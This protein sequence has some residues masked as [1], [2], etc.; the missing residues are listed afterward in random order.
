MAAISQE[1]FLL[2]QR[3]VLNSII[4]DNNPLKI[5]A[6]TIHKDIT[7]RI[8]EQGKKA[9][10]SDIGKYATAP[11]MYINPKT[12]PGSVKKL[13]PIGKHG[14]TVFKNGKPHKTAYVSSYKDYRQKI[15]RPTEKVNLVLSG[16]LQLDFA[17]GKVSNPS[18][19]K[20]NVNEYIV[21][22]KR[23]INQKKKDGAEAKYGE[24]FA[25]STGEVD[26]FV[27]IAEKEFRNE[28][29]KAGL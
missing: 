3:K 26:K 13:Q 28:F 2:R 16:D 15:G 14:E 4:K 21:T 19:Q 9:D 25:H 6:R 20:V 17:N 29:S 12:S 5:A 7:V 24:I 10:G 27:S 22:L 23:D 11:P 18:P 8:F 1:E